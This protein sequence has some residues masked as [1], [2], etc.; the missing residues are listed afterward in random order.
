MIVAGVRVPR[1]ASSGATRRVRACERARSLRQ[2]Q[3]LGVSS[4]EV[5]DAGRDRVRYDADHQREYEHPGDRGREPKQSSQAF[6]FHMRT[7]KKRWPSVDN[8]RV[9]K[10]LKSP[11]SATKAQ[12][13]HSESP[14]FSPCSQ[15]Q[16]VET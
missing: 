9:M 13:F 16:D 8:F 4:L 2:R 3:D 6:G 14:K 12:L 1:S 11:G 10:A 5:L 7:F 15:H